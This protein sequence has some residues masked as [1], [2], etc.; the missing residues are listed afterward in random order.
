M[1]KNFVKQV[2]ATLLI[3]CALTTGCSQVVPSNNTSTNDTQPIPEQQTVI[4][5]EQNN[6]NNIENTQSSEIPSPVKPSSSSQTPEELKHLQ[7][8]NCTGIIVA[9]AGDYEIYYFDSNELTKLYIYVFE[10]L[11]LMAL[12]NEASIA[13][14]LQPANDSIYSIL[15]ASEETITAD[16]S[17]LGYLSSD[18][19]NSITWV[20][21]LYDSY[22]PEIGINDI[23]H[24]DIVFAIG[25][26]I[27]NAYLIIQDPETL[28]VWNYMEL[29]KY[30]QWLSREI[31]MLLA[32]TTGF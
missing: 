13:G 30:G 18:V 6:T 9:R 15:N 4:E 26:N 2:T 28:T 31:D 25:E 19:E 32:Q 17:N 23:A 10:N 21:L 7:Q 27:E 29:N 1:K 20:R 11:R 14:I 22:I 5:T 8:K 24:K 3:A 16:I 12:K